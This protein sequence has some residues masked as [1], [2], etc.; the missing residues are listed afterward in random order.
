MLCMKSN[1]NLE[2]LSASIL[3]P[4]VICNK[5][6]N[7]TSICL[8]IYT[9]NWQILSKFIHKFKYLSLAKLHA[10]FIIIFLYN[11]TFSIK[12]TY[13]LNLKFWWHSIMVQKFIYVTNLNNFDKRK[14]IFELNFQFFLFRITELKTI[15]KTGDVDRDMQIKLKR[16]NN[17]LNHFI[18]SKIEIILS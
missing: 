12:L 1:L 7:F 8:E 3:E 18:I 15:I 16:K 13:F 9:Y 17:N 5:V 11:K 10:H 14:I 6:I 2:N 4:C